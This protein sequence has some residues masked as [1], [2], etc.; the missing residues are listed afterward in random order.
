MSSRKHIPEYVR[1]RTLAL[2]LCKKNN[3]ESYHF[4]HGIVSGYPQCCID[5]FIYSWDRGLLAKR[6][7][8]DIPIYK[9]KLERGNR[10][11]C[12]DCIV[13]GLRDVRKLHTK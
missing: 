4:W 3:M 9:D 10:I 5:F 13:R 6:I 2:K 8:N 1:E 7:R 11:M 12:P